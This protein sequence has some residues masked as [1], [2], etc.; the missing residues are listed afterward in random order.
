ML[1]LALAAVALA[2]TVTAQPGSRDLQLQRGW[3]WSRARSLQRSS[4]RSFQFPQKAEKAEHRAID[5]RS[6][7]QACAR[8]QGAG[9][10]ST[11][12]TAVPQVVARQLV[13][14]NEKVPSIDQSPMEPHQGP[15][16]SPKEPQIGPQIVDGIGPGFITTPRVTPTAVP[17][18]PS[19]SS[20]PPSTTSSLKPSSSP[21]SSPISPNLSILT[22]SSSTTTSDEETGTTTSET[23]KTSSKQDKPTS[24]P[25]TNASSTSTT[26]SQSASSPAPSTPTSTVPIGAIIGLAVGGALI[27]GVLVGL[28][29]V[30]LKK[31][32]RHRPRDSHLFMD[33][34]FPIALDPY[35]PVH[36]HHSPAPSNLR[37]TASNDSMTGP[38][39]CPR[40]PGY[41][42][43]DSVEYV[44]AGPDG[45]Y[46]QG[47]GAAQPPPPQ[48][49]PS[50]VHR[51]PAR[52]PSLSQ[53]YAAYAGPGACIPESERYDY[54][55]HHFQQYPHGYPSQGGYPV[56]MQPEPTEYSGHGQPGYQ[57]GFAP[58]MAPMPTQ[59]EMK[60]GYPQGGYYPADAYAAPAP[61]PSHAYPSSPAHPVRAP[62]TSM[63]ISSP[64]V[65]AGSPVPSA[66]PAQQVSAEMVTHEEDAGVVLPTTLPPMYRDEWAPGEDAARPA[67]S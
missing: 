16:G 60:G 6:A 51:T 64:V 3:G 24:E 41:E 4:R 53:G 30:R 12:C 25:S 19:S 31:R 38:A 36:G 15:L 63:G 10:H 5:D 7:V 13:V 20:R 18:P 62:S 48:R 52:Q 50:Y 2:A 67:K 39:N 28:F 54:D 21:P 59:Q 33:P 35:Y 14:S 42:A 65:S 23:S 26:P 44:Y 29:I 45:Y 8:G 32:T 46:D 57:N 9:P 55:G 1:M 11:P 47:T 58:Q 61:V 34:H 49:G 40:Q 37:R 43:Y 66:Q 17:L 56:P 22:T 27:I